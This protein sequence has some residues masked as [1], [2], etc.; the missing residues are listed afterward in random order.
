MFVMRA[1][2][3]RFRQDILNIFGVNIPDGLNEALSKEKLVIF[4]G[5]GVSNQPPCLLAN[6]EDISQL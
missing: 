6:F 5:A 2:A 4:A 1:V 3:R